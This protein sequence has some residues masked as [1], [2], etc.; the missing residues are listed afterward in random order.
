M[1]GVRVLAFATALV[2]AVSLPA[3]GGGDTATD[4]PGEFTPITVDL[5]ATVV[6]TL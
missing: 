2:V 4:E 1:T 6:G 3:C 5:P